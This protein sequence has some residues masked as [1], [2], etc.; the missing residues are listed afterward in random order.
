MSRRH[1]LLMLA[2]L[3]GSPAWLTLVHATTTADTELFEPP[4]RY[5]LSVDRNL[6]ALKLELCFA[7]RLGEV[8]LSASQELRNRVGEFEFIN[9]DS[10]V[11]KIA[12]RKLGAVF[13]N[14]TAECLRYQLSTVSAPLQNRRASLFLHNG[15]LVADLDQVLVQIKRTDAAESVRLTVDLPENFSLSAPGR[16]HRDR[17]TFDFLARPSAWQG[18]LALGPL[19]QST[20]IAGRQKLRLSIVGETDGR[21][22]TMLREWIASGVQ[23]VETAYARFPVS[24]VQ[25][26]VFPLP[27]NDDPVPWGEV[28]RGGGDAVHLYVDATRTVDTL[29]ANWVLSHELSHLLH[30][31]I[32]GR[33]AWLSEGIASYYQNV[34]RA[35]AG[36][37][38]AQVGW[39]KLHAGFERGRKQTRGN[40]YLARDTRAMMQRAHYMR[41]YWGGAAIALIGD[42][43]LRQQSQGKWTL[44]QLFDEV[45][46]CCLPATRRWRALELMQKFD[47]VSGY[48]IFVGLYEKYAMSPSFPDLTSTYA[49]LGISSEGR[50][51]YRENKAP[52]RARRSALMG[53]D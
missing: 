26:L 17:T 25:V 43:A 33:G 50:A 48:A 5:H 24:D 37:I 34:L 40:D 44:D 29:N 47:E 8:V 18:K 41:V 16:R 49:W 38:S 23:T 3:V 11:A 52:F 53:S 28:K 6:S 10:T 36:H 22:S 2:G 27:R 45:A 15:A 9:A 35:R 12:T 4:Y 7:P 39:E 51:V 46:R 14:Q 32:D 21:T 19:T 30:P 1:Q 13:S 31:Y 42:V 20:I